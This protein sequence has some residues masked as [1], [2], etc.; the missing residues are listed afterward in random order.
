MAVYSTRGR[1][2]TE[3]SRRQE[4]PQRGAVLIFHHGST[5]RHVKSRPSNTLWPRHLQKLPCGPRRPSPGS[6]EQMDASRAV[7]GGMAYLYT[8]DNEQLNKKRT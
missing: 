3:G 5:R 7:R 1:I 2:K 6:D 8:I 4:M